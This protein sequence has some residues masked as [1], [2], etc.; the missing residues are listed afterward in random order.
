MS[1]TLKPPDSG[2]TVR[3]YRHGF[4]DC[5]LLAFSTTEQGET[6]YML[7]D[8]GVKYQSPGMKNLEAVAKDIKEATGGHI[9]VVVIT[10][11]HYD[12]LAGFDQSRAKESKEIF[13]GFVFDEV[14]AAW[15]AELENEYEYN[16]RSLLNF[17]YQ[18]LLEA[19]HR[20][21]ATGDKE[22]GDCGDRVLSLIWDSVLSGTAFEYVL[23]KVQLPRYLKPGDPPFLVKKVPKIRVYVLGPPE[24][25]AYL[26]E[27][28]PG[29][30]SDIYEPIHFA[31][32]EDLIFSASILESSKKGLPDLWKDWPKNL[33]PFDKRQEIG[34]DEA[35]DPELVEK[36]MGKNLSHFFIKNYGFD[37][38]EKGQ[39]EKWKRIDN[40]WLTAA[41]ALAL[42]LEYV[43]NNTSLA[44]AIE[45]VDTGKVL[46]FSADAQ[47][48]NIRS[49]HKHSWTVDEKQVKM[50]DLL[51]RTVLY[52]VGHHG[53]HNATLKDEELELME[54]PDLVAMIPLTDKEETGVG[55][56]G[57][58]HKPLLE[59]LDFKAKGRVIRSDHGIKD[60]VMNK[61][62]MLSEDAWD[63]FKKMTDQ[64]DLYIDL[65]IEG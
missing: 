6:Y 46:L 41:E 4:G 30:D 7:I 14:W 10:H 22:Y 31:P 43:V 33:H 59:R 28:K 1:G 39:G 53:S 12:H 52:K 5:F 47:I 34:V 18:A 54:S 50:T 16:P 57:I 61:P 25:P 27:M 13:D 8:C 23:E 29:E 64:T 44:L 63:E 19:A 26:K 38:E 45:F 49:W 3:M 40:D 20:M 32:D 9:D 21:K 56:N 2:V 62:A 48:G 58:P 15:I 37:D 11:E 60:I 65:K 36:R 42:K 55:Y 51:K 17:Q 35:K 24:D